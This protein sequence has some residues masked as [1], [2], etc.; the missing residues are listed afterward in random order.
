MLEIRT[1]RLAPEAG[2]EFDRV[3]REGALPLL[4]R[5]G[6][7]IVGYGT[8]VHDED[9]YVL[10]RAYPSVSRR[11]EQLEGFY[12]SAEWQENYEEIVQSLIESYQTV[13][14]P[15]TSSVLEALAAAMPA[16]RVQ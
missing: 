7:H 9:Q 3:F 1:Y 14:I 12:G 8:S 6:V 11:D 2:E 4:E 15:L 10:M 16:G 5:F 13:V